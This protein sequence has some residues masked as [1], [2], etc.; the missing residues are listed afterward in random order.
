[1]FSE[2][3]GFCC[4]CGK[5]MIWSVGCNI[6]FSKKGI[7]SRKCNRELDWRESLSICG[8]AYYP[9]PDPNPMKESDAEWV[10]SRLG[11]EIKELVKEEMR[12]S[13][14][15]FETCLERV[16]KQKFGSTLSMNLEKENNL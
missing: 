13:Y 2:Q 12:N 11:E 9:D 16:L 6:P 7:C 15:Y 8:K 14:D 1:M 10:V 5:E 4:I 3:K